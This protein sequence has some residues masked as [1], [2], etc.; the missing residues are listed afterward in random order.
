MLLTTAGAGAAQTLPYDHLHMAAAEPAKAVAWYQAHLGGA[1]GELPDRVVVDRVF[2]IWLQRA[3]SP[4]SDASVIDHI[5]FSV[6][7]VAA[8]AA[9]LQAA[10]ATVLTPAHDAA[11]LF[12]TAVVEDPFGVKVELVQDADRAGLHH[13]HL[14]L[15]DPERGLAWFAER[16]GGERARLKGRIDGLRYDGFWLLVEKADAP[17]G[18]TGRAIDHLGWRVRDITAAFAGHRSRGDK[19]AGEPRP[20][21][22]LHVGFIEDPNGVRIEVLQ[23]PQF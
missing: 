17:P 10:G 7:D 12:R 16:F 4:K 21:R 5:A 18:S 13:V 9:E 11:G 20:V 3:N 23:R 1:L 2:L 8:K 19:I 22:D 15:P 6:P 14:R